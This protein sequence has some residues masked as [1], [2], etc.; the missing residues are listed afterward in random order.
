M[1]QAICDMHVGAAEGAADKL[2][3]EPAA[4]EEAAATSD[5]AAD[6]DDDLEGALE[7]VEEGM[8]ALNVDDEV[9]SQ[10][11]SCSLCLQ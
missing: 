7:S 8:Q 1:M 5:A 11:S 9:I 3:A 2:E 10:V 4:E 6:D